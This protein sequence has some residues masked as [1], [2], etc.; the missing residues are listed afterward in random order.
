MAYI[1]GFIFDRLIHIDLDF[2]WNT[3]HR[4]NSL[5]LLAPPGLRIQEVQNYGL[6]APVASLP[7][8]SLKPGLQGLVGSSHMANSWWKRIFHIY[9]T[10]CKFY[11]LP[12]SFNHR[13]NITQSSS[14]SGVVKLLWSP[15]TPA[16]NVVRER[17]R[18]IGNRI[19]IL[20]AK[21]VRDSR[22]CS[23]PYTQTDV[24]LICARLRQFAFVLR[25]FA[26]VLQ[27]LSCKKFCHM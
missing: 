27:D 19:L 18:T 25:K 13:I 2:V 10:G 15:G 23:R 9:M 3:S 11:L 21:K 7:I 22:K 4:I 14:G 17:T 1:S 16:M 26:F 12:K 6:L 20:Y 5:A 24:F 8:V